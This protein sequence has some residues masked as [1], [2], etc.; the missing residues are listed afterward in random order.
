MPKTVLTQNLWQS[1][2]F[3]ENY[4]WFQVPSQSYDLEQVIV[5]VTIAFIFA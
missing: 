2:D 1:P 5:S 3:C 4:L